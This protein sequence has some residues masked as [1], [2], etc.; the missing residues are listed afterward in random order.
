MKNTLRI[1]LASSFA[2]APQSISPSATLMFGSSDLERETMRLLIGRDPWYTRLRSARGNGAV[3]NMTE[4]H[5]RG[6]NRPD[7]MWYLK[8]VIQRPDA[9]GSP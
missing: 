4:L 9:I 2:S 3:Q 6:C 7:S 8:E 5:H 1:Y